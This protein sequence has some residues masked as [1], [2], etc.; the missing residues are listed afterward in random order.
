MNNSEFICKSLDFDIN[1]L[2]SVLSN[3]KIGFLLESS[4]DPYNL[5]RYSF[6]GIDPFLVIQSKDKVITKTQ[7]NKK[8]IFRGNILRELRLL[9]RQ[10]YINTQGSKIHFPFLGGA[11]GF[12]SYDL[13]FYLEKISRKNKDNLGIP[14]AWFAFFDVIL[15]VDH[16]RGSVLM[17]STGFPKQHPKDRQKWAVHR[18]NY[19]INKINTKIDSISVKSASCREYPIYSNF[20]HQEYLSTVDKALDYIQ[21]GDI[22]QVNLSQ[23]FSTRTDLSTEHLYYNLKQVF[24]VP[25]GGILKTGAIDIISGS[26][27]RF[28]KLDGHS[29]ST[30][31]MKGTRGRSQNYA[32]DNKLRKQLE[33]SIKDK[34]ELLMIVDLERNDLGRVCEYNT[35]KVKNLRTIERY[36]S[37]YQATAQIKG[38]LFSKCDRIDA[39]KACFPGGSITGCPKIRAME[40]IEELEPNRRNIYTGSLGYFSFCGKM[41]FNIL[42]RSFLKKNNQIHFGVGGGIVSDSKPE[43][44]YQ[45]TLVKAKALTLA[46]RG[47]VNESVCVA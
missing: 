7:N 39:L 13:G 10:Y 25:F 27:E 23:R 44:E 17:F 18:I 16:Y 24:P 12:F 40:I 26:P 4:L 22:Y 19:I 47:S 9:L 33:H 35:V 1:K 15:C 43:L 14:D 29:L 42:I 11:V 30:R 20:K 5:G 45:E 36:S 21:K 38:E 3:E 8:R 46:L 32:E 37:V 34:A 6:F 31:P 2:L 28:L 41:D